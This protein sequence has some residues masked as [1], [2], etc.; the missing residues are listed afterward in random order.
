M[1][2]G[3]VSELGHFADLGLPP[4]GG[5][6]GSR[7]VDPA[8]D[9]AEELTWDKFINVVREDAVEKMRSADFENAVLS[10]LKKDGDGGEGPAFGV[11]ALGGAGLAL[12]NSIGF[13]WRV[14]TG[15]VLFCLV[16]LVVV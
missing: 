1:T 4:F 7:S 15:P 13:A 6:A 9:P 11:R 12:L 5:E 10:L 14:F 8:D 2:G 3:S 16:A